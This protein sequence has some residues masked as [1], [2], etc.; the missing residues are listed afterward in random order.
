MLYEHLLS[1]LLNPDG[2]TRS[3]DACPARKA[4]V[5]EL[6]SCQ[7]QN[8]KK[9]IKKK[10]LAQIASDLDSGVPDETIALCLEAPSTS[11]EIEEEAKG[12]TLSLLA[13]D[14]GAFYSNI[15]TFRQPLSGFLA[16]TVNDLRSIANAAAPPSHGPESFVPSQSR[17]T[18][19]SRVTRAHQNATATRQA[20]LSSQLRDRLRNLRSIQL[21]ELPAARREM[22]ATAAKVL[23][24]RTQ[25]LER[26]VVLLERV[27]HGTLARATKAKAEHLAT[28]AEGVEGKLNVLKLE[29]SAIIYTPDTISALNK[30]RQHLRNV[31]TK[32]VERQRLA[33]QELRAY[34]DVDVEDDNDDGA[35][36]DLKN[37][38]AMRE[39]ARRYG[40]LAKK[41]EAVKMEIKRLEG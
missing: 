33:T 34:G 36:N 4:V 8:A 37:T 24:A 6:K 40:T 35:G 28:V 1:T 39:I 32:L 16:T 13:P 27:K 20:L 2:S 41:L 22:A 30:Y 12:E 19:S 17:F 31:R 9:E 15:T 11:R 3:N 38:G 5:E 26:T 23:A 10:A 18:R 14:I 21:S 25:V 29:I 7:K